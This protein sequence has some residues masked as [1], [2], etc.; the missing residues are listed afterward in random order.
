LLAKTG[1][2]FSRSFIIKNL[3]LFTNFWVR[4]CNKL[5]KFGVTSFYSVSLL[6]CVLL[7][8]VN[9]SKSVFPIHMGHYNPIS[10]RV[11]LSCMRSSVT[12][13][14]AG[15]AEF[16]ALMQESIKMGPNLRY[17]TQI[18]AFKFTESLLT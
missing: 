16:M 4:N 12:D 3:H 10:F 1:T 17:L 6:I 8:F 13:W 2:L 9:C 14:C 18:K 5:L 7:Y 15:F 11:S